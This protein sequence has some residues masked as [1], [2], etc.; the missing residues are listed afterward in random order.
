MLQL[1]FMES[2]NSENLVKARVYWK[3]LS[4]EL[5]NRV[6]SICVRNKI[7]RG[8]LEGE[9]GDG[10]A[11]P[12]PSC[13]QN[14]L[15]RVAEGQVAVGNHG[16]ALKQYEDALRC[17]SDSH[18]LQLTFMEACNSNNVSKEE[19]VHRCAEPCANDLRPQQDHP[20]AARGSVGRFWSRAADRG[21]DMSALD[22]GSLC[23]RVRVPVRV[24]R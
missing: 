6:E 23:D 22:E 19:A 14:A 24:R 7:N 1:A 2:C 5:Q 17:K 15:L 21:R 12:P 4:A 9:D 13:D 11:R 16:Q 8:M 18:T 10:T 3:K 20:R